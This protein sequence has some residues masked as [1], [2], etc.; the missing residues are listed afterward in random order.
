MRTA[1]TQ[2]DLLLTGRLWCGSETTTAQLVEKANVVVTAGHVFFDPD[3]KRYA[4]NSCYYQPLGSAK[5]FDIDQTTLKN[6]ECTKQSRK[7]AAY[8]WATIKL[9]EPVPGVTPY[10][11]VRTMDPYVLGNNILQVSAGDTNF[12][13]VY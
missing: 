8:D 12:R 5:K 6:G 13:D 2:V 1:R 9:K 4:L 3:C 7:V 11:L 10:A